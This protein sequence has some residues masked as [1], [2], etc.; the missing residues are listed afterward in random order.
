MET[1]LSATGENFFTPSPPAEVALEP[2]LRQ[3]AEARFKADETQAELTPEE[4]RQTLHELRVHQIEL[5]L[6]NDD[7][8][9]TQAELEA[10]RARYFDLYELAPVGYVT[11]SETGL[12]LE[13]NLTAAGLLGVG[14]SALVKQPLTP[15][16][17]PDDQ[18][19]FYRLR[20]QLFKT[21]APQACELRLRR[22]DNTPFCAHLEATA[23]QDAEG[24]PVCRVVLSDITARKQTELG[25]HQLNAELEAANRELHASE[26][27]YRIIFNNEI[28]AI[29]IFDLETLR[30][31]DVNG[32]YTNLYGYSRE[33]LTS[34]M[35]IHDI[36]AEHQVSEAATA[37]AQREGTIYI[38]LRY[39]R[40]KDGTVFPVEIVGGPYTWEGHQVMFALAHDITARQRA[41]AALRASEEKYRTVA[42]FTH[43]WEYWQAPDGSL[44]YISPSCERITGYRP[45]EFQSDP[46]LLE[47][48]IHPAD[49]A[50]LDPHRQLP[51]TGR[52]PHAMN[53]RILARTGETRWIGHVCQPVYS[54]EGNYL[55]RRG[56]QRDI[57]DRKQAEA[58]IRRLN[59][60]L[61]QQVAARTAQLETA[62]EALRESLTKYHVLFESFPLGITISDAQGHVLESNRLAERLLGLT[63]AAHERRQID[64]AEWRIIRPD[65][66]PMPAA[67]YASVRA[68]KEQRL[69]ENVEMGVVKEAGE[70]TWISVTAAPL[71]LEGYGVAIAYSDISAQRQAQLQLQEREH[72]IS[73]MMDVAPVIV[74]VYDL[75]ERRNVF[76][77][78]QLARILGYDA[79]QAPRVGTREYLE[80]FHPDDLPVIAAL[81][82]RYAAAGN[83]EIVEA[84]YRIRDA[85]GA[86]H[87]L[88]SRDTVFARAADGVPRQILGI[89]T[90]ITA[91]KQ[92]EEALRRS[93]GRFRGLFEYSINGA[94]L[95]EM[96]LNDQGEPVDYITLAANPAYEAHTGLR[97]AEIVGKRVTQVLPSTNTANLIEIYG[98]VALTGTSISFETYF[99]PLRRHFSIAAYQVGQGRF[100]AVFENITA[101]KQAEIEIRQLNEKLQ[102]H[103]A[104]LGQANAALTQALKVKNEFLSVMSHELRTPL[105]AVLGLAETLQMDIYGPVTEKQRRVLQTIQGSGQ[106]LLDLISDVL[107]FV[108]VD[109]GRLELAMG[110]IAVDELCQDSLKPI[111]AAVRQKKLQLTVYRDSSVERVRGDDRLLKKILA[112]LLD[113]AVKFTPTGGALG[114]DVTG[115][116]ARQEVDFSVW[117]TGIGIAPADQARL[118]EPFVQLDSRLARLYE[119]TGLGLALVKRLAEVHGGR[120]TVE[121]EGV[122]GEGSRF[123]VSL[124][125]ETPAS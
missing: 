120:V 14:R 116:A 41:E 122:S 43:D 46:G 61:E 33:E 111:Q 40:K 77:N 48:I 53:F 3:R 49:R 78:Q 73:R 66:A 85:Q 123:T 35:T 63:R 74:Y 117:D 30:L 39:H 18:D 60:D 70:V 87:W 90:D 110:P 23:A 9:R 52:A 32:A 21:G 64:G 94:A 56:S 51:E 115:D 119:G 112:N 20:Q 83:G 88:G 28:Y 99:E 31:L 105:T 38:P 17:L 2:S 8:R 45:A 11:L 13:A 113:N 25:I 106:H 124:P 92:A 10:S 5:E 98:K 108:A 34:G 7:L 69:I 67:E 54:A 80:Q 29:C 100:A 121:S 44:L 97:I 86:W 55:G 50:L 16:I 81:P 37:Q 19:L 101:R 36:T 57:T 42:D 12:I 118:F 15:F 62:N 107:E 114:L 47:A 68:L 1:P 104:Q 27:K 93:E 6:Q 91:R 72:F 59:A 103:V 76:V 71:P 102:Q 125:W 75:V 26:E 109:A 79:K 58:E 24:A 84:E 89:A 22:S 96:V 4:T 95:H 82:A 65:G